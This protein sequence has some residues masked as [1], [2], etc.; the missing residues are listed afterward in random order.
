MEPNEIKK[1]TADEL[2]ELKR[3]I[4]TINEYMA[5]ANTLEKDKQAYVSDILKS[6]NLDPLKAYDID[7]QTGLITEHSTDPVKD[8]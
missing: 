5:A 6:Y 8:K 3:K 4:A 2:K 1:L 7:A